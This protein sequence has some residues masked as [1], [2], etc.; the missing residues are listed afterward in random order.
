[1]VGYLDW[2]VFQP[3]ESICLSRAKKSHFSDEDMSGKKGEY[4]GIFG[5]FWILDYKMG[6]NER[7]S[8]W[9]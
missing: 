4:W 5:E 7:Y 8:S 1:M 3:S 9:K 2:H 6:D